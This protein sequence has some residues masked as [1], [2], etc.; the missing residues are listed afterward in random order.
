MV[1]VGKFLVDRHALRD[2]DL[3]NRS[4]HTVILPSEKVLPVRL[5]MELVS[6]MM[7]VEAVDIFTPQAVYDG[8]KNLFA[9]RELPF[10]PSGSQEVRIFS[11]LED[12]FYFNAYTSKFNVSL[13]DD[14]NRGSPGENTAGRGPKV[15]KIRLTKVATINPE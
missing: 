1:V 6:H 7:R 10:G 14:A 3:G 15:Y 8:R 5:N 13:S 12:S 2:A 11:E 4:A 9:P